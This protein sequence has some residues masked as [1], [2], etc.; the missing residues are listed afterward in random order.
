MEE[1]QI[2]IDVEEVESDED[3]EDFDQEPGES[4]AG[5][6]PQL[7]RSEVIPSPQQEPT[8]QNVRHNSHAGDVKVRRIDIIA[9]GHWFIRIE[10]HR[11]VLLIRDHA[12]S[13]S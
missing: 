4:R 12:S 11:P 6:D 10:S 9:R 3:E 13:L 5:L 8:D 1:A 7:F 2:G